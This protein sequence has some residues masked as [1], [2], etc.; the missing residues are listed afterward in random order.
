[1]NTRLVCL[2]VVAIII[3]IS[4]ALYSYL[5]RSEASSGGPRLA[6][7]GRL[8]DSG[9]LSYPR[10]TVSFPQVLLQADGVC[11]LTFQ[12]P[13]DA[14]MT[15][16]LE[17]VGEQA[18]LPS[19]GTAAI[20]ACIKDNAGRVMYTVT[21]LVSEWHCAESQNARRLWHDVTRDMHL[22]KGHLYRLEIKG[23]ALEERTPG[24]VVLP[25]LSGGGNELP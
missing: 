19:K 6:L 4:V 17:L 1:M 15:L 14:P 13:T 25:T 12:S 16:M 18:S 9:F 22:R 2:I 5:W 23:L 8:T 7:D 10:F 3:A 21:D 11:V 20:S 24:V